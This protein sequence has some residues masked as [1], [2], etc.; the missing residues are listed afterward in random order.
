MAAGAT[1]CSGAISRSKRRARYQR[2]CGDNGLS[3]NLRPGATLEASD[4]ATGA[5]SSCAFM[6]AVV[7]GALPDVPT[8]WRRRARQAELPARRD[9]KLFVKAAFAGEAELAIASDR[10]L[11][12]RS[13]SLQR[14][15]RRSKCRWMPPGHR[16]SALVSAYR[17][18]A[19]AAP[20]P[21]LAGRAGRD[22]RSASPGSAST[23]SPRTLSVALAAPDGVAA[24]RTGRD[25]HQGH[26]GSPHEEAM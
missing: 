1:A 25:R 11:T 17:P 12:L 22:G 26:W 13:I 24:A 2:R 16:V 5:Q 3:R 6:S 18:Q 10:I 9:G 4:P 21:G 15:A 20:A 7:E 19:T 14:E 23:P 8:S